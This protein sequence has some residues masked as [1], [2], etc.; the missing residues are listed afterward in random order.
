MHLMIEL[1]MAV[2]LAACAGLRAWMPLLTVGL[3]ARGGYMDLNTHFAFLA[4]T[5]ALIIF[6][7]ATALELVG[8]KVIGI[9]HF[10]DAVGTAVRPAAA[11]ILASSMLTH[12]DPVAASVFGLIVGGGTALTIHGAKAALRAK[13]SAL[14]PLHGG[15]GNASVSLGEDLVA[16]TGVLAVLHAPILA[17]AV[18]ACALAGAVWLIVTCAHHVRRWGGALSRRRRPLSE[19]E[20]AQKTPAGLP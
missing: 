8:D 16:G 2:S 1:M 7:V 15:M 5:D 18:T 6:G 20:K 14:A 12:S 13:V 17:F 19:A 10:L 4:R 3:L 9:D 11:T